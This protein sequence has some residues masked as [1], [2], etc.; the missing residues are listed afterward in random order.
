MAL[1]DR[2]GRVHDSDFALK[3]RLG[4]V[5]Y[6]GNRCRLA[7]DRSN[8]FSTVPPVGTRVAAM[9]ES[10]D[11]SALKSRLLNEPHKQIV[12]LP[13]ASVAIIIDP[14]DRGGSVLLIKRTERSNDPW[15]G[16][17][18]FPG[19]HVSPNDQGFLQ[20][21]IREAEEEVGL[22]LRRE[23]LLG[24]LPFVTTRSR[25]VQVASY[26]FALESVGTIRINREVAESFWVPL[27]QMAKLESRKRQVHVEE[28]TLEVDSYDYQG[29]IIWGLTF[30]ILNILFGRA[31]S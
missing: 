4:C 16:Q 30:R 15:S 1:E 7:T 25:R 31:S 22:K 23:E 13:V 3:V 6:S 2:K 19:G 9:G 10:F 27:N 20:T 5:A 8:T 17:I 11:L 21:A 24:S 26:A 14:K 12:G 28:G 29:H 18:G